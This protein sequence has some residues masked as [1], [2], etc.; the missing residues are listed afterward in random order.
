MMFSLA[1][2]AR[3]LATWNIM[4]LKR[5]QKVWFF[6]SFKELNLTCRVQKLG[7][8]SLIVVFVDVNN[9]ELELSVKKVLPNK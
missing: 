9:I 3:W 1:E 4:H 5:L 8:L 6:L 7:S 2:V